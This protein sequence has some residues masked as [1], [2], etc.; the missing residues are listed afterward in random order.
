MSW[1][2]EQKTHPPR[3]D[4]SSTFPWAVGLPVLALTLEVENT[5]TASVR[6][7]WPKTHS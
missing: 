5:F 4:N 2:R 7:L 6:G 1:A 3:C